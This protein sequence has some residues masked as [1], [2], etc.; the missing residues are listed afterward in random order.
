VCLTAWWNIHGISKAT[1]YRFKR[2]ADRG[3][4]TKGYE[5]FGFKEA[6]LAN[7]TCY[8]NTLVF[9]RRSNRQNAVEDK[10]LSFQGKSHCASFAINILVD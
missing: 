8:C 1:F 7:C 2:E 10:N 5:K 6:T 3:K 9:D 4:Q